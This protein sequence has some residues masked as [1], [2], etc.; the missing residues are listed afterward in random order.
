MELKFLLDD[1]TRMVAA[2]DSH[3]TG[4]AGTIESGERVSRREE[5]EKSSRD[6]TTSVAPFSWIFQSLPHPAVP[7]M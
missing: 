3:R 5:I 4:I 1:M 2:S 7:L 6:K